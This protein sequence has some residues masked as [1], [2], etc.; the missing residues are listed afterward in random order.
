VT[1]A[2]HSVQIWLDSR[3]RATDDHGASLVEYAMLVALI[4]LI[5]FAAV[6]FL[7]ETTA[8][9]F[10]GTGSSFSDIRAN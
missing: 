10:E 9:Q 3:R 8:S 1:H 6:G 7:G 2:L 4:A 5:C